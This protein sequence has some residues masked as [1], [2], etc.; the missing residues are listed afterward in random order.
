M[1][2]MTLAFAVLATLGLTA[3]SS[4]QDNGYKGTVLFSSNEGG[5][6]KLTVR[7]DN[8]EAAQRATAS[9][10]VVVVQKYD[11]DLVVGACVRV[12]DDNTVRNVSRSMS[13]ATLSRA[14]I[15]Y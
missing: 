15:V 13:H 2:K 6:L 8:C 1:K 12:Y 10:D 3:C 7:K 4:Q 11:S 5:E 9:E 14:S